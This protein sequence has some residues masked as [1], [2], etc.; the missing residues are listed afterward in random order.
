MRLQLAALTTLSGH[1]LVTDLLTGHRKTAAL[2]KTPSASACWQA[3]RKVQQ[4]VHYRSGHSKP[5]TPGGAG[6]I[7]M[8]H[9][10]AFL[11]FL[12][13]GACSIGSDMSR[14]FQTLVSKL[15]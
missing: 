8:Q 13:P 14:A 5:R 15:P 4:I 12:S 7:G 6:N 10:G 11:T 1:L 2:Q 3:T 9:L